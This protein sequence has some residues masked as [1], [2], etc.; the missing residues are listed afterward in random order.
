MHVSNMKPPGGVHTRLDLLVVQICESGD[1][2]NPCI[3][4][5]AVVQ[6]VNYLY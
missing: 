6:Q 5:V 1:K 2:P 3:L 4:S